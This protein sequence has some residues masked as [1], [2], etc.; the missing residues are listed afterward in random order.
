MIDCAFSATLVSVN[1]ILRL[2]DSG[3]M[4]VDAILQR[5]RANL[6]EFRISAGS[7]LCGKRLSECRLPSS[8]I[9]ALIFREGEVL[10]PSGSTVLEKDDVAVAIVAQEGLREIE[11]LFPK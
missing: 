2:L 7:P 4:R 3:A 10:T 5:V 11:A 1:S 6:S 8:L 9:L